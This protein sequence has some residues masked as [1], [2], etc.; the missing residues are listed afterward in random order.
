MKRDN[1]QKEIR[2]EERWNQQQQH[3]PKQQVPS[4]VMAVGKEQRE[5]QLTRA[6]YVQSP[7]NY[8]RSD[9]RPPLPAATTPVRENLEPGGHNSSYRN[10]RIPQ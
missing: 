2:S 3:F 9:A 10:L 7:R 4:F 6:D 1:S 8:A 5:Y